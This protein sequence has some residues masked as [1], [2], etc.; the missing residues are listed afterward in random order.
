MPEDR[1]P[2]GTSGLEVSP[3]CV[4]MVD[5]PAV[6]EA[7]F[8]AGINFFFVTTDMHWPLYE[9]TRRGLAALLSRGGGIRDRVVVAATC[10]ATQPEFC[11]APFEELLAAVPAL[12]RIDVGVMGGAYWADLFARLPVFQGHVESRFCGMRAIASSLHERSAALTAINADLLDLAFIRYNA[13]HIG[14]RHDLLPKVH[15]ERRARIFNFKSTSAWVS[16]AMCDRLGLAKDA[17]C[18]HPTDHYRYAL[19]RPEIDGLLL[20]LA[21]PEQVGELSRALGR[22]PLTDDEDVYL[23]RLTQ[24]ALEAR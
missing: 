3:V 9:A 20:S 7:A 19:T 13:A 2:L 22:G 23:T 8:D 21:T 1:I 18:P 5:D 10:Y 24:M 14:A 16:P 4:G 12:E 11:E 6:V 17:W 15:E